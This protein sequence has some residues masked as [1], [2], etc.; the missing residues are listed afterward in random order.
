MRFPNDIFTNWSKVCYIRGRIDAPETFP[1]EELYPSER[2]S[3]NELEEVITDDYGNEMMNYGDAVKYYFNYQ[4]VTSD[5]EEAF[6]KS[7]GVTS[8]GTVRA[9]LDLKYLGK[10]KHYD[11]AYLYGAN[12]KEEEYV[13]QLANYRVITAIPQ[14]MKILVYFEKLTKKWEG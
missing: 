6:L 5:A 2:L 10:L 12:P 8:T 11:L 14:N 7:Y 13:G 1:E 4:P 9:L 3:P